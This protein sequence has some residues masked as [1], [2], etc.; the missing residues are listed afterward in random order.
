MIQQP[1]QIR[2][3]KIPRTQF[4][5]LRLRHND[6]FLAIYSHFPV[7]FIN[8]THTQVTTVQTVGG[9][10]R[11]DYT[12]AKEQ[13]IATAPVLRKLAAELGV[14]MPICDA[15]AAVIEGEISVDEAIV[16]LLMR[17]NRAEAVTA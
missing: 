12:I 3:K 17:P 1:I 4:T 8:H 15:V 6:W 16:R 14:E 10:F 13:D 9:F 11:R 2:L 7:F 5:S